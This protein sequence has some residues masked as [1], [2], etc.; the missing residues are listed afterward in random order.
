MID[1]FTS[2]DCRYL[3]VSMV[4]SLGD[5]FE[6]LLFAGVHG[7]PRVEVELSEA[8]N[9]ATTKF[10]HQHGLALTKNILVVKKRVLNSNLF[11]SF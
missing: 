9:A 6:A 5:P 1:Y 2:K 8:Q 3:L 4:Y 11:L 10:I 7:G